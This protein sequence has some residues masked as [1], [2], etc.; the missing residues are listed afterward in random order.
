MKAI[1]TV[2]LILI[3]VSAYGQK[4][5]YINF[6]QVKI[7]ID[8]KAKIEFVW[9]DHPD[10]AAMFNNVKIRNPMDAI[11]QLEKRGFELVTLNEFGPGNQVIVVSVYMRRRKE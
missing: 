6:H 11:Q 8:E 10:S 3:S 4:Y 7:G 9:P 2:L 5:E 1:S